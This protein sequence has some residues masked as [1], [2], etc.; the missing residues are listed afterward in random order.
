MHRK[1]TPTVAR[2]VR[3]DAFNLFNLTN[4]AASSVTTNIQSAQ[5]GQSQLGSVGRIV[6]L[7]ASFNF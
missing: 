3:A 5:F 4:L 2:E 1:P 6:H 7:Q